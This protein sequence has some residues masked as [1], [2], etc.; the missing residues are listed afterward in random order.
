MSRVSPASTLSWRRILGSA[1]LIACIGSAFVPPGS[2]STVTGWGYSWHVNSGPIQYVRLPSELFPGVTDIVAVDAGAGHQLALRRDGTVVAR[3]DNSLGQA[4]VPVGLTNVIAIAAGAWHSLALKTNGTVVGW[5][6]N[7]LGQAMVPGDLTHA[8]AVAAGM[9]RSVALRSDGTVVYWGSESVGRATPLAHLDGAVAIA[10]GQSHCVALRAD[11]TVAVWD[12]LTSGPRPVPAGFTDV[13]G[14]SAGK[15]HHLALRSD[16]TVLGWGENRHGQLDVPMFPSEVIDLAAGEGHSMALLGN[17]AVMAWGAGETWGGGSG[18]EFGQSIVPT[19]VTNTAAI[20]CGLYSSLALERDGAPFLTSPLADRTVVWGSTVR[21]RMTASGA[22]PLRF[23]WHFNG[24]A[25]PGATNAVLELPHISG[26]A[27]GHYSLVVENRSG[28]TQSPPMRITVLPVRITRPPETQVTVAGRSVTL[29]VEASGPGPLAYQWEFNEVPLPGATNTVLEL[30]RVQESHVGNYRVRVSNEFGHAV[31]QAAEVSLTR[32]VVWGDFPYPVPA[33]TTNVLSVAGG[34]FH[35]LALRTDGTVVAWGN[36]AH[37]QTL[38]PEDLLGVTAIAAG[39][40]HSL[41]LRGDGTLVAWGENTHGQATIP[42]GL[43]DVTAIASYNMHNLA[44]RADGTVV[45]WGDNASGQTN[46]PSDLDGVVAVGA[47]W[48]YSLALKA[49]GTIVAWGIVSPGWLPPGQP[50]PEPLG[51]VV[52]VACGRHHYLALRA[53]GTVVSRSGGGDLEVPSDLSQVVAIAAG[54]GHNLALRADGTVVGWS[55]V[56]PGPRPRPDLTP[57]AAAV[58]ADLSNITAI[59]AGFSHSLAVLGAGPPVLLAP[60]MPRATVHGSTTFLRPE[61]VGAMPLT[62][63]WQWNGLDIEGATNLVL[64]LEQLN[65]DQQGAYSVRVSNREGTTVSNDISLQVRPLWITRQP[66]GQS[67]SRGTSAALT[68]TAA[69]LGPF[70]YQ[71]LWNGHELPDATSSRLDLP[72]IQIEQ[73][74][75]YSVVVR[76][77]LGSVVSMPAAVSV[78][79]L[80]AW[81]SSDHGQTSLPTGLTNLVAVAAGGR[82]TVALRSDGRV[83]AWGDGSQGQIT[84]PANA[85]NVVAIQAGARHTLALRLDGTVVGW[86]QPWDQED[87]GELEIPP[88]AT[89]VV[90]LA[91]GGGH[92]LALRADGTVIGW[93]H[94]ADHQAAVPSNLRNVTAIAAGSTH[95][96]AL[97]ADGTVAAW[98]DSGWGSGSVPLGL[99]NITAIAAGT[100]HNLALRTD[101]TV[102]VWGADYAGQQTVPEGLD[103]VVAIAAGGHH[104][105]V[106]QADGRLVGWGGSVHGRNQVPPQATQVVAFDVGDTHNLVLVDS[107]SPPTFLVG[108]LADSLGTQAHRQT[109]LLQQTVRIHNPTANS[110]PAVRVWVQGLPPDARLWN[111]VGLDDGETPYVQYDQPLPPMATVDLLLEVYTPNR[112]PPEL[113]VLGQVVT[114][115]SVFPPVGVWHPIRRITALPDGTALLEFLPLPGRTYWMQFSADLVTWETVRAPITGM[116]TTQQWRDAGPPSTDSPPARQEARFYRLL[117]ENHTP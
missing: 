33:G 2:A 16:G 52:A 81:G 88:G 112:M 40:F 69:G 63:Q 71:W 13:V 95:S 5:G 21:V 24:V 66:L 61:A 25:L 50:P 59:A 83:L 89:N 46:V 87:P 18:I 47:G 110:L 39:S 37:G 109:G 34:R 84:P 38:V 60:L 117:M 45:A 73:S 96:L 102:V 82:H 22:A 49:D 105:L 42:E 98:G 48:S 92:S 4:R 116:N 30:P 44:L 65:A 9:F 7:S 106:L 1:L 97:R 57:P 15:D 35:S 27:T 79:Q 41:A 32:I 23:Q 93:G 74:G 31:S 29:T 91:A 111:A 12:F 99:S 55:N 20:A 113:T 101:G 62:Y 94:N 115:E 70:Q 107:L 51:S 54:E 86:G 100:Q 56:I 104:N 36:N 19:W 17:G 43:T 77:A 85:T 11:G 26:L 3:G 14:V 8:I 72:E 68:V 75:S 76:N 58:P 6:D 67:V 10:S 80:V 108:S 53:N 114:P 78:G 28:R 64:I 103:Q 90:A